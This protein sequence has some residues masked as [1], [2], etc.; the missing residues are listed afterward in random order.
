MLYHDAI[1]QLKN[2]FFGFQQHLSTSH[3]M[4]KKMLS[5][6]GLWRWLNFF[7]FFSF[8]CHVK[9]THYRLQ[10]SQV[11]NSSCMVTGL[12]HHRQLIISCFFNNISDFK[13]RFC[14]LVC[15]FLLI[16]K[17]RGRFCDKG[18]S[19]KI[20]SKL[21]LGLLDLF[22]SGESSSKFTI[23]T[24]GVLWKEKSKQTKTQE[25]VEKTYKFEILTHS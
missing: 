19:C 8:I 14:L 10:R 24:N 23:K 12:S 25:S 3:C 5:L 7:I 13:I 2:G 15:F 22:V 4:L 1:L 21:L 16:L 9:V 18:Q 6:L 20:S 17:C 11:I